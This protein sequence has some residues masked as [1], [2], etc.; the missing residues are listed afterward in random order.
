ML[1][2]ACRWHWLCSGIPAAESSARANRYGQTGWWRGRC[3]EVEEAA[4]LALRSQQVPFNSSWKWC[5]ISDNFEPVKAKQLAHDSWPTNNPVAT[6]SGAGAADGSRGAA[7]RSRCNLECD[8]RA[9]STRHC[10][11]RHAAC[12]KTWPV[13]D[14]DC[15]RAGELGGPSSAATGGHRLWGGAAIAAAYLLHMQG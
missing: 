13:R 6:G 14:G 8:R 11:R 12:P 5:I 4:L 1:G 9:E 2:G 10:R 7:R 15:D 3:F